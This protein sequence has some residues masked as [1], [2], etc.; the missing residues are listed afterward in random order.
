MQTMNKKDC[1]PKDGVVH[2]VYSGA[3]RVRYFRGMLLDE[4][5]L[6]VD[7][8]YH[9]DMRR[10]VVHHLHG[11]GIICG[12]E[13]EVIDGC[14]LRIKP[15]AALDFC[16]R[17]IEV[18]NALAI[19]LDEWCR[20][21]LE[22]EGIH[23]PEEPLTYSVCV[24]LKYE[25]KH[26]SP[27]T[28]YAP[29]GGCTAQDC[30]YSRTVAGFSVHLLDGAKCP[31]VCCCRLPPPDQLARDDGGEAPAEGSTVDCADIENCLR[32]I[33]DDLCA[34]QGCP[35]CCCEDHVVLGVVEV[36]CPGGRVKTDGYEDYRLYVWT[37]D[38]IAHMHRAVCTLAELAV[39]CKPV[40]D[41][42]VEG[43]YVAWF[44]NATDLQVVRYAK[45]IKYEGRYKEVRALRIA[46]LR[47]LLLEKT[48][49]QIA[50]DAN[51]WK[52]GLVEKDT[53]MT[54]VQMVT[55]IIDAIAKE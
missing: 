40:E 7:Q 27:E 15:G 23:C 32:K 1:C 12:L 30:E 5:D 43:E 33:L 45:V 28:V 42:P 50:T 44:A 29:G 51:R 19:D 52:V 46:M 16:G 6:D 54:K 39:L 49:V 48:K 36:Q 4:Q 11:S 26:T 22:E 14:P 18:P 37:A 10:R 55:L 47:K 20:C 3:E 2:P 38:R 9:I 25:E 35:E 8:R 34:P 17:L 41:K 24:V 21:K 53:V 31:K 13:L